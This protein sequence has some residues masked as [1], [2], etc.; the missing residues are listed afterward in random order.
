MRLIPNTR[1]MAIRTR[2]GRWGGSRGG[3]RG[4][5]LG[6]PFLLSQAKGGSAA[7]DP[8]E[9]TRHRQTDTQTDRQAVHILPRKSTHPGTKIRHSA[10]SF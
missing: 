10:P 8:P 5:S 6:S 4:G 9:R 1:Q 2:V 7:S 3:S